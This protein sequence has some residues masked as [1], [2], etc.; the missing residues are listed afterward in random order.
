MIIHDTLKP[1]WDRI[2]DR[3]KSELSNP[4]FQTFFSGA[5]PESIEGNMLTICVPN[6]FAKEWIHDHCESLIAL[7]LEQDGIEHPII[8]YKIHVPS[9]VAG[10]EQLSIFTPPP[11]QDASPQGFGR[12]FSFDDFIVGHNNR[13]AYAASE[14]VSKAP[15]KAYNPL[16]IYGSVGLGK[17]HLLHAIAHDTKLRHPKLKIEFLSS[18]K[19][20]NE[21]INAIRD[22]KIDAFRA[23][24]RHVDVLLVDDIQFLSGKEQTQEEF[25]H[26]FNDLHS[27]AKQIV[28]T[29]DRPPKEIPTLELRL[30]TR[31]EWGLIADIQ[32]PEFE[33]RIAILRK[34][35]ELFHLSISD[36]ILH[37]IATQ[38]PTNVREM[39]GCLTRISAYASLI[40]TDIT[41]AMASNV[42]KDMIGVKNEKPL[43]IQ[44]IKRKIGDYFNV[45]TMDLISK[46]RTRDL[47]Y[48]RQIAMYLARELTNASLPKI[49]EHFGNRDHSTVMHA[50]DKV[51]SMIDSDPETRS[52][53]NVLISNI[54]NDQ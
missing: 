3:L 28:L 23:K 17:T 46:S 11:L 27:N 1:F 39:E 51:K 41:L 48:P 38:I 4:G 26:T 34:K 35:T 49:G 33:T 42:I 10:N 2:I 19:F 53:I 8:Q 37:Y 22:K 29:C 21:L 6:Q 14:A 20:T 50:C 54:K 40:N 32:P 47:A 7:A 13:F 9:V 43:T 45:S 15:A 44:Y 18:E 52:I 30:R 12:K 36:D 5:F 16:F 31:F 24:Y 25:F